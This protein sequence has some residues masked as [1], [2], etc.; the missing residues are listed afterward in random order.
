MQ[1]SQNS[2]W[3]EIILIDVACLV[4][5]INCIYNCFYK[6]IV[7]YCMFIDCTLAVQ[8]HVAKQNKKYKKKI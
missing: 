4:R 5:I 3:K 2:T 1:L 6:C 7:L 8:N